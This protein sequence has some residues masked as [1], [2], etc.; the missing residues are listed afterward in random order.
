MPISVVSSAHHSFNSFPKISIVTPSFNQVEYL[1]ATILSILS[2]NYPNLEYII[3]D[4][5]STDGSIDIIQKYQKQLAYWVSEPDSGLYDAVQ[6]GFEKSTGEIMAWLNSD[7][8]YH[9][10]SLFVVADIFSNM[11]SVDWLTGI[12]T[13]YDEKNRTIGANIVCSWSRNWHLLMAKSRQIQQE[14]TFWRRSLWNKS[15]SYVKVD[16]DFA[17]DF[18]LWF[19]FFKYA[20]LYTVTTILGGFRFRTKNQK[21]LESM[22]EYLLETEQVIEKETFN[23]NEICR[24]KICYIYYYYFLR[25]FRNVNFIGKLT[26]KVFDFPDSIRF[27]RNSSNFEFFNTI[28][29]LP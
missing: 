27:N 19:R 21:S 7:D 23:I 9:P 18:E 26:I 2:Q 1:E 10:N 28:Y 24:Q 13:M 22:T 5:G 25:F 12:Y 14:S 4:G 8:M 29:R 15:G 16:M 11:P 17:G 3:I 6:K 20:D